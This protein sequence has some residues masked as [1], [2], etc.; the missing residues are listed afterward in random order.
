MSRVTLPDFLGKRNA[1]QQEDH[2]QIKE[3]IRLSSRPIKP[4][5]YRRRHRRVERGGQRVPP[6]RPR[7]ELGRPLPEEMGDAKLEALLFPRRATAGLR[8]M[9]SPTLRI[10]QEL[11][12]KG[13]TLQLLWEE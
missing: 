6:T 3:V 12:R 1:C 2:A 13:V 10:C 4:R 5:A 8:G 11:K 7:A 9:P